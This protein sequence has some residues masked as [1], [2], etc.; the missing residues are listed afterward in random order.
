MTFFLV[1]CAGQLRVDRCIA[2]DRDGFDAG[3]DLNSQAPET[4]G[5]PGLR[6]YG[7]YLQGDDDELFPGRVSGSGLPPYRQPRARA[8]DARAT[9][10]APYARQ[11]LFG[12]S[13]SAAASRRG[14]NGGVFPGG[15]SSG[16]G[17][18]VRQRAN[19]ATAAPGRRAQ[20]T[21][22]CVREE[23]TQESVTLNSARKMV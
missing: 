22:I 1:F 3:L 6:L 2:M 4:E 18:G 10:V 8:G 16:G 20:R 19:S 17:R 9:A 12:G 5:F 15:L 14:R 11:L 7:D 21:N 23:A 13:S